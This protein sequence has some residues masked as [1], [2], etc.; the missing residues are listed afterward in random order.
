[1]MMDSEV[2]LAHITEAYAA[3]ASAD[4]K[5]KRDQEHDERMEFQSI[6]NSLSPQFCDAQLDRIIQ[7]CFIQAGE[8]L[9]RD[10]SFS[11]WQDSSNQTAK[12]LWLSGI[13]GAGIVCAT[14]NNN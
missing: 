12:F 3:R 4:D 13:P 14:H 9:E 6:F 11:N 5:Y 2:T 7:R 8:W 10:Q 1:M